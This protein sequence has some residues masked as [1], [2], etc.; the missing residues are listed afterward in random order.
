[1]ES[2]QTVHV[3]VVT[4]VIDALSFPKMDLGLG[5]APA[6]R[7]PREVIVLGPYCLVE[8]TSTATRTTFPKRPL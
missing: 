1:M 7:G 2:F 4:V 3:Y 6:E 5:V 8:P